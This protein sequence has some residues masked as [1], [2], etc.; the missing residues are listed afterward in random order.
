MTK[1]QQQALL[2][3][4]IG[5]AYALQSRGSSTGSVAASSSTTSSD[6]SS[7]T[8]TETSTEDGLR[9]PPG[10]ISDLSCS[11]DGNP[12][13]GF[14]FP[15]GQGIAFVIEGE[16]VLTISPDGVVVTGALISGDAGTDDVAADGESNVIGAAVAQSP[17]WAN[18]AAVEFCTYPLSLDS[19]T[20]FFIYLSEDN[21]TISKSDKVYFVSLK[22]QATATTYLCSPSS[23]K[24]NGPTYWDILVKATST[25]ATFYVRRNNGSTTTSTAAATVNVS[26]VCVA[27]GSLAV[28]APITL[29]GT[30]TLIGVQPT[31]I[32][33]KSVISDPTATGYTSFSTKQNGKT[34]TGGT[35]TATAQDKLQL[36]FPSASPARANGVTT[37]NTTDK[38]E[39]RATYF[40][41][42]AISGDKIYDVT[43]ENQ[44]FA[45][46]YVPN[47]A[48][49]AAHQHKMDAGASPVSQTFVWPRTAPSNGSHL[50]QTTY[51]TA[52]GTHTLGY[53]AASSLTNSVQNF[54]GPSSGVTTIRRMSQAAY[55]ALA[56]K[57]SNTLYVIV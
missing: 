6:S 7:D 19:T 16:E 38:Y 18:L 40:S 33:T 50:L 14:Y 5:A 41:N 25:I 20:S 39:L 54:D 45:P 23:F 15:D 21:G 49:T 37:E 27:P 30:Y 32:S 44:R 2:Q 24:E 35:A 12:D 42:D 47:D 51:A 31:Q 29:N 3:K 48:K 22:G 8:S 36:S 10:E 13:T 56:S 9:L 1:K 53:V 34:A 57:N 17:S 55:D 28:K 11:S 4:A 26:V 46:N 52:T 43:W